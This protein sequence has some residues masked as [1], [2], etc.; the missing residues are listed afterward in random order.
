MS[1]LRSSLIFYLFVAILITGPA[2][3][4][5]QESEDP[6]IIYLAIDTSEYI[7]FIFSG[8]LDYN[9][10]IAASK[11]YTSEIERLIN[12]GA[13][14]DAETNEGATPLIFAVGNNKTDAVRTLLQ[15]NPTIDQVTRNSETPLLIAV[16]NGNLEISEILIR[17]GADIRYTDRHGATALHYASLD[18]YLS[19][20]DMLL[21]YDAPINTQS[22]EG[23]TPLMAAVRAG[24]VDIA[25]LLMQRG[26]NVEIKDNEGY[27]PFL[28]ASFY[29]DTLMM[30]IL[31]KKGANIYA[32]NNNRQDALSLTIISGQESAVNFLFSLGYEWQKKGKNVVDPYA[33]ASKYQEKDILSILKSNNV[34]GQLRYHIDQ[35]SVTWSER[36]SAHDIFSG[37][38]LAFKEP[39]LNGG[40]IF[41][42]DTKLW[43]TRVLMKSSEDLYFQYLNK[44]SMA[45]AGLFKDFS[46]KTGKVNITLS[47]SLLAGYS[48]GSSMKGT[49]V[50]PGNKVKIIPSASVLVTKWNLGLRLGVE[51]IK[52]DF[53]KV[54]PVWFRLGL[55]YNYFFDKIRPK[56]KPIRWN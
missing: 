43:Y 51:Y 48:F 6:K 44:E 46:E 22:V 37:L 5:G 12:K 25:D 34:P 13:D 47:T 30:D 41:G 10:M 52:S 31:H 14:V 35:A 7:P 55:S 23:I 4:F 38:S 50:S 36:F 33:V 19:L 28:M 3:I 11:G 56:I 9:L 40:F 15:Y 42:C 1:A 45:Y 53:Y 17:A 27:T 18:N 20:A 8:A 39:Y 32:V 21:Y 54:G 24:N 49:L 2:K 29:G 16:K 26:A